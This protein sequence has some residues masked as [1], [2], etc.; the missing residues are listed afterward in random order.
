MILRCAALG[1]HYTV[2]KLQ[3]KDALS[4]PLLHNTV[5]TDSDVVLFAPLVSRE[6]VASTAQEQQAIG[7]TKDRW[8]YRPG[9]TKAVTVHRLLRHKPKGEKDHCG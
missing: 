1:V 2:G 6:A 5:Y 3:Y 7:Q 4:N 9:Q 8:V